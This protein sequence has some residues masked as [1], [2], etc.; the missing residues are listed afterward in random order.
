[1]PALERPRS[2]R[3]RALRE[4][5]AQPER[6]APGSASVVRECGLSSVVRMTVR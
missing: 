4:R 5:H 2:V 3:V 6:G 1:M